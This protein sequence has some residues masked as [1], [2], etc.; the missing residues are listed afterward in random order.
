MLKLAPDLANTLT[1]LVSPFSDAICSGVSPFCNNNDN[2][3]H[4]LYMVASYVC[5][6]CY[7]ATAQLKSIESACVLLMRN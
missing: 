5:S 1:A 2:V 6:S 4:R 3:N 7:I